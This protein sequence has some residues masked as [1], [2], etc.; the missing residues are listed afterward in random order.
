MGLPYVEMMYMLFFL[1]S[2]IFDCQPVSGEQ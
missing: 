1:A 2:S